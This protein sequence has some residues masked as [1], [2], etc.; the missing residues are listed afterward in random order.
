MFYDEQP[1]SNQEDYKQM[2]TIMGQLSNLFSESDCPYLAYRAHE[3]IFCRYLEA[4]NLARSDCSADAKKDGIGIGLKT[5]MGN[6]DQKVAEFGKL[7][8]NYTHLSG[9]ELVKKIAVLQSFLCM[10][11]K[12]ESMGVWKELLLKFKVVNGRMKLL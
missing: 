3:N 12:W 5:W 10:R 7:K 9:I 2:L 6:D 8:K 4:Q 11:R 1:V